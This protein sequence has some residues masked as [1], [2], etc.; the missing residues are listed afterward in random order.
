MPST[1]SDQFWV[2]DPGNPPPPGTSLTVQTF[3]VTGRTD[4]GRISRGGYDRFEGDRITHVW[5]GDTIT[6]A[7]GDGALVT[8]TGV[9]Y[10]VC[11]RVPVFAPADG[12]LLDDATFVSSTFVTASTQPDPEDLTPACFTPGTRIDT[13]FGAVPVELIREGDLVRTADHGFLPVRRIDRQRVRAQG[14][15]AP[16]RFAPGVLRNTRALIV[17]PQHR[18]LLS[19]WAAE[20][21]SHDTGSLVR[22]CD[23]VDGHRVRVMTGGTVDY[24][25]LG[26]DL[27]A[28]VRSEGVWTES[29]FSSAAAPEDRAAVFPGR[30]AR[31]TL[32]G[33]VPPRQESRV[34]GASALC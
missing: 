18:V 12:T 5:T 10:Y 3:D 17:N 6:V 13:A 23:L 32:A 1:F 33:P 20:L 11:G 28:L 16:V 24:F 26:F 31:M 29:H 7:L 4:D 21:H 25:H 9:T 8:V 15:F 30:A 2:M 27:H 34:I 22:A 19:G 14:R